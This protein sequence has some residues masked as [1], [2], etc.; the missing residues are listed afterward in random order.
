LTPQA[1]PPTG[2]PDTGHGYDTDVEAAYTNDTAT[3]LGMISDIASNGDS[4][5]WA[6]ARGVGDDSS[7]SKMAVFPI[8]PRTINHENHALYM[9]DQDPSKGLVDQASRQN[10]ELPQPGRSNPGDKGAN[11]KSRTLNIHSIG[12]RLA[13]RYSR[14]S[15]EHIGSVLRYSSTNSWRSSLVSMISRASSQIS[16]TPSVN[17]TSSTSDN[18]IYQTV[19]KDI[20][21]VLHYEKYRLTEAEQMLW[22]ILI[23]E[24]QLA[25]PVTPTRSVIEISLHTRL[26]CGRITQTSCK[27]CGFT[28]THQLTLETVWHSPMLKNFSPKLLDDRDHFDNTPLHFAAANRRPTL[29]GN[30]SQPN[31][32]VI[33]SLISQGANV[34]AT[35]TSGE[36][37]MHVLRPARLDNLE[38]YVQLLQMLT[39]HNFPFQQRDYHGRTLAHILFEVVDPTKIPIETLCTIFR[40]L[41]PNINALDNQGNMCHS[42]FSLHSDDWTDQLGLNSRIDAL[43]SANREQK[44]F[45]RDHDVAH[46]GI[47]DWLKLTIPNGIIVGIDLN[48]D[49]ALTST[50]KEWSET[51]DERRLASVIAD[52]VTAGAEVN[53]RDR[54]GDTALA[55]AVRRGLRPAVNVLLK[56]GANPNSRTYRGTGILS[57]A[58][59][60]LLQAVKEKNNKQYAM[61]LSCMAVLTDH[62]ATEKPTAYDEW[63]SR[64]VWEKAHPPP[65]RIPGFV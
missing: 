1:P 39:N 63:M 41:K 55:I 2:A 15:L 62:G 48:G 60:H 64:A 44:F 57:Q 10:S 34:R 45:F 42:K 24:S 18:V 61:I 8:P 5:N 4:E 11:V 54:N 19:S 20:A 25:E 21:S 52:L 31:W 27:K 51:E 26:C 6:I 32:G 9:N 13:N 14:S 29:D 17:R 30:G 40:H 7:L 46:Y 12:R 38:E 22:D 37:F 49:S 3:A 58:T 65:F 16:H 23:D 36:T 59:R 33:K 28:S 47:N 50:I 56:L 35:N 43:L 53:M